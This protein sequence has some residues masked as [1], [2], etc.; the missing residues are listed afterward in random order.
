MCEDELRQLRT[1]YCQGSSELESDA[2][3]IHPG[4][5]LL[6]AKD[7]QSWCHSCSRGIKLDLEEATNKPVASCSQILDRLSYKATREAFDELL[8][9]WESDQRLTEEKR[10]ELRGLAKVCLEAWS[11][12]RGQ[13]EALEACRT[14]LMSSLKMLLERKDDMIDER[15]TGANKPLGFGETG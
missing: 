8:S 10:M 14:G 5:R 1:R 12:K 2:T 6:K 9:Y 4:A 11:V 15:K 13:H 3:R 7:G